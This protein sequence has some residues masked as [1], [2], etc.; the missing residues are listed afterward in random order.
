ML[1]GHWH[2]S[3]EQLIH[4]SRVMVALEGSTENSTNPQILQLGWSAALR[5]RST[6]PVLA[7]LVWST[8]VHTMNPELLLDHLRTQ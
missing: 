8:M 3:R 7:D 1:G 6:K 4:Q 5:H 2:N